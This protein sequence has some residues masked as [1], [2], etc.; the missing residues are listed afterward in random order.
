MDRHEI[1]EHDRAHEALMVAAQVLGIGH[2]RQR[3][4][5]ALVPRAADDHDGQGAPVH[6]RVGAGCRAGAGA[7]RDV[8]GTGA[9]KR[10]PHLGTP[11][12][13]QTLV[14]DGPVELDL[15]LD[16]RPRAIDAVTLDEVEDGLDGE[17]DVVGAAAPLAG[18]LLGTGGAIPFRAAADGSAVERAERHVGV[19]LA[20]LDLGDMG[21]RA[22]GHL[23][24][25][26]GNALGQPHVA[27]P[28]VGEQL[29]GAR[30]VG[31]AHALEHLEGICRV[32]AHGAQCGSRLDAV[33]AARI[34][35]RHALDVLDD[36]TRARDL[37]RLGL[38]SQCLARERRGVGDGDGLG[39][40]E[41]TD[42]FAIEDGTEGGI[43]GCGIGHGRS[44]IRMARGA[45]RSFR[46]I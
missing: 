15:A 40:P 24:I 30:T 23:D 38:A 19:V 17:R 28:R 29:A 34:G 41:R 20:D 33:H 46:S 5:D 11:A 9:E 8:V 3:A 36:V 43:A 25:E 4:G 39:A 6:A 13:R 21:R 14:A 22:R 37:E 18:M 16:R 2:D 31:V 42:E 1:G 12:V 27:E 26:V 35:D 32:A 45:I 10:A 44:S 7:A